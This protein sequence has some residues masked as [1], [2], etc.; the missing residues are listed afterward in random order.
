[1]F[2]FIQIESKQKKRLTKEEIQEK[3]KE[4]KAQKE[5][6]KKLNEELKRFNPKECLKVYI[7]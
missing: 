7:Y 4:E 2:N 3:K 6:K 5:A 1:M